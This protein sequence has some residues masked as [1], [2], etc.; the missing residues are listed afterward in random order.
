MNTVYML[1]CFSVLVAVS[2]STTTTK[3]NTAWMMHVAFNDY[4]IIATDKK[5]M[6]M[7]GV[8]E[9]EVLKL[10]IVFVMMY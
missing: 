3:N 7:K 10:A 6:I 4:D 5:I 9:C 2:S 1:C 8:D